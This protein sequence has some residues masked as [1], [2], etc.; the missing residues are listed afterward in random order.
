MGSSEHT[1]EYPRTVTPFKNIFP[2]VMTP[3][4]PKKQNHPA[5]AVSRLAQA[6]AAFFTP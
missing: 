3:G 5:G 4:K 1:L 2:G 6:P